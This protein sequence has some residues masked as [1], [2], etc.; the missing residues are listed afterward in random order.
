MPTQPPDTVALVAT[1]IFAIAV[2]HTFSTG[3][4]SAGPC[5]A[6]ACG[7]WHLLGEVEVVFGFWAAVLIAFMAQRSAPAAR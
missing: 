5:A 7:L 4:S 3:L 2:L 1:A 6:A